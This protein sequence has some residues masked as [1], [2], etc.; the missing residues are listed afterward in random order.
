MSVHNEQVKLFATY[1]NGIAI[2]IVSV[3]I[4]GVL[5]SYPNLNRDQVGAALLAIVVAILLS[6][7]IHYL[8][9]GVLEGLRDD[10]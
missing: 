8:A 6:P 4:L 9:L 5:V 2:A 7:Y 3:V 1:L 10:D